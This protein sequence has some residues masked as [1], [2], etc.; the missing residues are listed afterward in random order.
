[1]DV[2]VIA[3]IEPA[4]TLRVAISAAPV[5][6]VSSKRGPAAYTGRPLRSAAGAGP[7]DGCAPQG[8]RRVHRQALEERSRRGGRR[9][10]DAG[11][12]PD[13]PGPDVDGREDR[14]RVG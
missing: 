5:G 6:V 2:T 11:L 9:R 4:P 14:K 13:G 3:G 8:P 12:G 7:R 1:M 10:A